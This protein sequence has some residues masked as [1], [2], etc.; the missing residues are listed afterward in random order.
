LRI[1]KSR[2]QA[3]SKR[4]TDKLTALAI[5]RTEEDFKN[6]LQD[7]GSHPFFIHYRCSEQI[8]IYRSYCRTVQ[9]PLLII[10]ATGSVVNFFSKFGFQKTRFLFLYEGV[11]YDNIKKHSFTVT[12]MISEG[13]DSISI[14]NWLAKWIKCDIPTPNETVCDQ[15]LTLLSAIVQCFTKYSSLK[16]YQR[17]S[18]NLW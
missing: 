1:L 10:D 4:H 6:I 12:T 5:M 17:L 14:F 15:S 16:D 13:H 3:Q 7:M 8:H 2:K 11:V 9:Y 18:E